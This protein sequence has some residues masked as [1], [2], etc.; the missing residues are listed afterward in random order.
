VSDRDLWLNVYLAV[1][2]AG[3]GSEYAFRHAD[4]AVKEAPPAPPEAP[5][6]EE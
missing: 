2:E 4:R 3:H 5:P 1:L 6:D